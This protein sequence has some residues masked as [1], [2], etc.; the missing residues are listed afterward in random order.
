MGEDLQLNA[1]YAVFT[2]LSLYAPQTTP[3]KLVSTS[4]SARF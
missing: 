4:I 1:I 2:P 3:V